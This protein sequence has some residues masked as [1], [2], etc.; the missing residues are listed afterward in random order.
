MSVNAV[1]TQGAVFKCSTNN[2]TSGYVTIGD[3]ESFSPSIERDAI[4]VTTLDSSNDWREFKYGLKS[5][6]VT[7]NI[8]F[9]PA[10]TTHQ[11]LTDAWADSSNRAVSL[12]FTDSTNS[13][14]AF[15]AL[16]TG[17]SLSNEGNS[18]VK[19]TV[20]LQMTGTFT[21]PT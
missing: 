4:D 15:N 1:V 20:N 8:N 10:S 13:V 19:G 17:V 11:V 7:V 3:V 14:W 2:S 6:N 21:P 16:V 18:V 5:G 9:I 12:T